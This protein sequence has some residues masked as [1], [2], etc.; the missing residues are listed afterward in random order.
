MSR[1]YGHDRTCELG[2]SPLDHI[3]AEIEKRAEEVILDAR[4]MFGSS[5]S[6]AVVTKAA[7]IE[8]A[9]LDARLLILRAEYLGR[10][11]P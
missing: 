1:V 5:M 7:E 11:W 3:A 10:R 4:K 8:R 6:P 2:E 9:L